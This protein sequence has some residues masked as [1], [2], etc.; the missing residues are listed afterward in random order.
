MKKSNLSD[1]AIIEINRDC[2]DALGSDYTDGVADLEK[3]E[4]H[5]IWQEFLSA[6][7]GGGG[8]IF[9]TLVVVRATLRNGSLTMATSLPRPILRQR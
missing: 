1:E 5:G 8:R 6:L 2:Y 3:L 7:S 4:Q 9:S